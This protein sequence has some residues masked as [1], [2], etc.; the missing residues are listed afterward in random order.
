MIRVVSY[1]REAR[2]LRIWDV[3]RQQPITWEVFSP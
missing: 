3:N 1:K 2:T